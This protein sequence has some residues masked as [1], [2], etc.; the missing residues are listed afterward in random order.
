MNVLFLHIAEVSAEV[1]AVVGSAAARRGGTPVYDAGLGIG[2]ARK[3]GDLRGFGWP[4][5]GSGRL[6][7]PS[8]AGSLL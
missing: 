5:A 2:I 3:Q 8:G 1:S 6:R 7:R 4:G